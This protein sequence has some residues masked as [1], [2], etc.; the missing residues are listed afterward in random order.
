MPI[1]TAAALAE[2]PD[3]AQIR[4]TPCSL[5]IVI[6]RGLLLFVPISLALSYWFHAVPLWIFISG[7]LA[8]VPLADEIRRGTDSLAN[9]M[10]PAIGG[11]SRFL[12]AVSPN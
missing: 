6:I 5:A 11:W 4:F 1:S 7:G 2:F 3:S 12:S 9:R 10:G 8:I